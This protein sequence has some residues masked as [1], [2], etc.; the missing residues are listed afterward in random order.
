M[1]RIALAALSLALLSA[2]LTGCA[3]SYVAPGGAADPSALGV[4]ADVG[5]ARRRQTDPDVSR[6]LDK[7]PLAAFPAAVAFVR[8]QAPGYAS[9]TNQGYGA[10]AYSVVTTRDVEKDEHL[11]RLSALPMLAGVAPINRLLLPP[12]LTDDYALREAAARVHADLLLV[13]TF[14][15]TFEV[16]DQARPLTVVTLGLSPSKQARVATTVSAVL[17]DTRNGYVYGVAEATERQR[18]TTNAWQSEEAVDEAR[19]ATESAAFEKLVG[20]L[21]TMWAGVVGRYAGATPTAV[22]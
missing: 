17:M 15:T 11:A 12:T 8:V 6:E 9:Y 7:R 1:H 13:Y 4:P 5:Q 10:G 2:G 19:R 22:R 18:K 16:G 3:S 20:E 21:E 14:D